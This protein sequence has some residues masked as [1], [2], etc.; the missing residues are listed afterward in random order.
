[1]SAGLPRVL[2]V[3]PVVLLQVCLELARQIRDQPGEND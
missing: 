2:E 3:D 1:M